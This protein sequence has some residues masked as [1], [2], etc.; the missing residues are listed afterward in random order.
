MLPCSS[1]DDFSVIECLNFFLISLQSNTTLKKRTP[2]FL[3]HEERVLI[4][5]RMEGI[6]D[7]L[8]LLISWYEIFEI[9][10]ADPQ[11]IMP[12]QTKITDIEN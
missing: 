11:S 9:A 4:P 7:C 10:L 8:S 12:M 1:K 5:R 2:V 6:L 3:S